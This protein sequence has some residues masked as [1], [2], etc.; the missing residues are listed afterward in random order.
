MAKLEPV[1]DRDSW[2]ELIAGILSDATHLFAKE[3][4]LAKLEIRADI[5]NSKS[6][7]TGIAVGAVIALLGTGSN[8]AMFSLLAAVPTAPLSG[9]R[10]TSLAQDTGESPWLHRR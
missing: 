5:R 1:P 9:C 3:I 10:T 8:L 7:L 2:S 4:E 6:L